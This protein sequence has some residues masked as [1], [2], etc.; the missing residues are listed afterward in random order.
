MMK[1][2]RNNR[3]VRLLA[4]LLAAALC[5]SF[6][7]C[8]A[9]KTAMSYGG[10]RVDEGMWRYWMSFYK[11]SFLNSY[12]GE[13]SDAFFGQ[14][15]SD[16]TTNGEYFTQQFR[17]N[18]KMTLIGAYQFEKLGL[19]L[20]ED[21]VAQIDSYL[22]SRINDFGSVDTM[23][24]Y[25]A[26]MGIDY[27][28][29]REI[30]I[31]E[32]KAN[33]VRQKLYGSSTL[34]VQGSVSISDE[35]VNAFYQKHYAAF[36]MILIRTDGIN[37]LNEDGSAKTD[38]S[39][40]LITRQLTEAERAEKEALAQSVLQQV[41][42]GGDFGVLQEQ[43]NQDADSKKFAAGYLVSDF[44]SVFNETLTDAV[45]RLQIGACTL[46]T[47][48]YGFEIVQRVDLPASPWSNADYSDMTEYFT[49][50]LNSEHYAAMIA[51]DIANIRENKKVT[52]KYALQQADI[53][54][55]TH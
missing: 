49:D 3:A 36:R 40:K 15:R 26:K 50:Y 13:D 43:Y 2:G 48:D 27:D 42:A 51:D 31:M 4:V 21:A 55:F 37:L 32:E 41:Q 14:K 12:H 34:G 33:A 16:G 18:V 23:N 46:V 11:Y 10:V 47:D 22:S 1:H 39:G 28:A 25:L 19:T 45:L 38:E 6:S 20:S 17:E 24:E 53:S 52:E 9:K 54:Y 44:Y 29:L 5:L 8:F 7:A 30:L 35:D